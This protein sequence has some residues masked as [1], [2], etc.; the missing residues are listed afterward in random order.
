[1]FKYRL[2]SPRVTPGNSPQ[3]TNSCIFSRF[4]FL[5]C[6]GRADGEGERQLVLH[7]SHHQKAEP[8]NSSATECSCDT[9]A[10]AFLCVSF[11]AVLRA[12]VPTTLRRQLSFFLTSLV[13]PGHREV[14]RSAL[15][16]QSSRWG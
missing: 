9:G 15:R 13:L 16:P 6:L 4:A 10:W 12:W 7:R 8:L 14:F 2:V 5:S 3:E 1:M 11:P